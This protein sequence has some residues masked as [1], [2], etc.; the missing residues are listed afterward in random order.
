MTRL[1]HA[2]S[3]TALDAA[4][5]DRTQAL[6]I[7]GS[8]GIGLSGAADYLAEKLDAKAYTVLPEKNEVVDIEA[9]VISVASI[10]RLYEVTRTIE[11]GTRLIVIDYAERMAEQAQNAFL[12]LLEEPTDNTIF[13]MLSHDL[14]HLLPTVRSRSRLVELR[15]ITAAQTEALLDELGV[16]DQQKRS[17]LLFMAEG[18]PA[19]L[20]RLATDQTY[21]ENRAQIIRDAR[22]LLQGR[23]YEKLKLIHTYRDDR[24]KALLLLSDTISL[25]QQAAKK[26]PKAELFQQLN[27]LLQ[28][29]DQVA[30]N[31][32]IRLQLAKSVV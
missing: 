21:F 30:A 8:V 24:T 13:V 32:N 12:K 1:F 5:A 16:K 27:M 31:G 15:P 28:T 19:E 14:S 17:Q 10:R 25:L 26:S 20:R 22:T 2:A 7:T 4:I 18:L 29:Y 6:I 11:H 9:G 3:Q 23:R